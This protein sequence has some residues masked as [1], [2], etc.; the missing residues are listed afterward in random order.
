MPFIICL[1]VCVCLSACVCVRVCMYLWVCVHFV[2]FFRQDLEC[3]KYVTIIMSL[4]ILEM[5]ES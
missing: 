3:S 5:F 1:I 2:C 4:P